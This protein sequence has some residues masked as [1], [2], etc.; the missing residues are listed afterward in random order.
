MIDDYY[1][2]L[3]IFTSKLDEKLSQSKCELIDHLLLSKLLVSIF[4]H[5]NETSW[6]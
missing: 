1:S 6:S 4:E 3:I 2:K 5:L